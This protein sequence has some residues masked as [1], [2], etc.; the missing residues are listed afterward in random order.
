M[1][2]FDVDKNGWDQSRETEQAAQEATTRFRVVS[3]QCRADDVQ[4]DA[5]DD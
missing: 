3:A 5:N 1:P 2:A 4:H